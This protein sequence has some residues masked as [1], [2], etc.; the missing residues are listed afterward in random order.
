MSTDDPTRLASDPS[1]A[2]G[3]RAAL[4]AARAGGT[5]ERERRLMSAALAPLLAGE[6]SGGAP[7]GPEAGSPGVAAG[8]GAGVTKTGLAWL[9]VAGLSGAAGIGALLWSLAGPPSVAPLSPPEVPRTA[10]VV[11]PEP[12]AKAKAGTRSGADAEAEPE[13]GSGSRAV[14]RMRPARRRAER[15]E[16]AASA[17]AAAPH[18]SARGTASTAPSAAPLV[19]PA[20]L[21]ERARAALRRRPAESLA[22][23]ERHRREFLQGP[24]EQERE[25]I[26]I[27]ALVRLGGTDEARERAG[28]FRRLF[29]SSIHLRHI[30]VLLSGRAE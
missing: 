5:S 20:E 18:E 2:P 16:P 22:L 17:P 13:A 3:L 14:T 28:R 23:I 15:R 25:V 21:L 1:I 26:A 4:K 19:D 29:P 10:P 9:S 8:A 11:E 27:E 30:D 24:L 6:G 7:A 12:E